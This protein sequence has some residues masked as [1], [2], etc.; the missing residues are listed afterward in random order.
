[1]QGREGGDCECECE[2]CSCDILVGSRRRVNKEV[3]YIESVCV[4]KVTRV[5]SST[6]D[7]YK[8][9]TFY[10]WCN[11]H[12]HKHKEC[13]SVCVGVNLCVCRILCN[14]VVFCLFYL[15][16]FT[17]TGDCKDIEC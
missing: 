8:E 13:M 15:S 3:Q 17:R 16:F 5:S 7:S 14:M 11:L 10:L 12:T 9:E 1:M 4:H 6:S 2:L